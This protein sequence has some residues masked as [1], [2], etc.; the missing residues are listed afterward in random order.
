LFRSAIEAR[1][2]AESANRAK[3]EFLAVM[4]H[5]LRTPLNA[6][7]GYVQLLEMGLRGPL[8][9]DQRRDL[10]RV[11]RSQRHLLSLINDILNYARLEAGHVDF[12]LATVS[13]VGLFR[14]LEPLVSP[15]IEGKG[16]RYSIGPI[17]EGLAVHVDPE[18]VQ[19]ILLNL[20]SNAVK[21]TDTG[22]SLT[23]SVTSEHARVVISLEDTG[24]GIPEDKLE[25][26]FTPFLQ[27]D[28][29]LSTVSEGTGLGLAI[30]RD[31]ARGMG[32]DLN[33]ASE[34]G[35]GSTFTLVLP[36]AISD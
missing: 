21:F 12:N 24:C 22:G 32:G 17:D 28:R 16:L 1:Q 19:Q 30:S 8:T 25:V 4:S 36:A 9:G 14:E 3:S 27:L 13:V 15:L 2:L 6:I 20:V 5:E 33:A 10:Q 26:I 11:Q 18:K 29:S 7:A 23:V 34:L 31:L 35:R